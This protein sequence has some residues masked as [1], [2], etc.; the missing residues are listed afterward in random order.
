MA[1]HHRRSKTRDL[2]L[3]IGGA[4]AIY[5]LYSLACSYGYIYAYHEIAQ[6]NPQVDKYKRVNSQVNKSVAEAMLVAVMMTDFRRYH[7]AL[8]AMVAT[9]LASV[10]ASRKFLVVDEGIS[11]KYEYPIRVVESRCGSKLWCKRI[12]QIVE[13]ANMIRNGGH[14]FDWLLTTNEDYYADI[15]KMHESLVGTYS[16]NDKVVLSSLGCGRLCTHCCSA[17]R[18]R[19]GICGGNGIVLSRA[20]V[21]SIT[22]DGDLYDRAHNVGCDVRNN[23]VQ[24]DDILACIVYSF[25]DEIQ[26]RIATWTSTTSL[27]EAGNSV[28]VHAV[29]SDRYPPP[30]I[31]RMVH[32]VMHGGTLKFT[33]PI[34]KINLTYVTHL[35]Q[36]PRIPK[37]VHVLWSNK[38]VL[39]SRTEVIQHGIARLV[40]MSPEWRV[41]VHDDVD[42][43]RIIRET[44]L[45]SAETKAVLKSAHIIERTDVVRLILIYT[46][47]GFYTDIDRVY[48]VGLDDVI[49]SFSRLVVPTS[50]DVNFAQDQFASS[51]GNEMFAHM[52]QL[53]NRLRVDAKR[54]NGWASPGAV[55]EMGPTMFLD[56]ISHFLFSRPLSAGD[57]IVVA[58]EWINIYSPLIV[59]H[60]EE[61]CNGLLIRWSTPEARKKCM[62]IGRDSLYKE[63]NVGT[64]TS[65]IKSAD[66]SKS[67]S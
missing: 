25:D 12:A 28:A 8:E 1:Y 27:E 16:P 56:V 66:L 60:K 49:S 41:V 58:R 18:S 26:L 53:Q 29:R 34:L 51:P 61:W 63:G 9:W 48:N 17:I 38:S 57:D 39:N 5:L 21:L 14:D 67:S 44:H 55:L 47:G 6:V 42:I 10:P 23:W 59:T 4:H 33:V 20:A 65:Q 13:A 45:L 50:M 43:A 3:F 32:Q 46:V 19:G 7:D 24:D 15:P 2:L 30:S 64:W 54:V 37:I 36:L 22:Q 52:I 11:N 35:Q 40:R 62:G 31:I